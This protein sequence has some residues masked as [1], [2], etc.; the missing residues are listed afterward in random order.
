MI[1]TKILCA[2]MLG[3]L[4]ANAQASG[5]V[6]LTERDLIYTNDQML[7]FSIENYLMTYAPH[8]KSYAE[9]IS[10]WAGFSSISPKILIAL[11][12]HQSSI[13][14]IGSRDAVSRPFGSLSDKAGF[15]EQVK[16]ISNQL[17]ELHY[18]HN[19][20]SNQPFSVVKLLASKCSSPQN[21]LTCNM[22]D[23]GDSFSRA[24]YRLFPPD[25]Q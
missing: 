1:N 7:D 15:N 20:N 3:S 2:I 22:S 14:S 25:P 8:I 10:H 6:G 24:Y 17:A 12:E 5:P 4:C 16:D 23:L 11:M 21:T 18:E 9:S 19:N 13:I